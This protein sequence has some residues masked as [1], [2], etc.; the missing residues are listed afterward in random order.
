MRL[1]DGVSVAHERHPGVLDHV[2]GV[3]SVGTLRPRRVPQQRGRLL[4]EVGQCLVL[5]LPVVE[6]SSRGSIAEAHLR[7]VDFRDVLGDPCH[8]WVRR[9]LS[10]VLGYFGGTRV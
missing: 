1:L 6:E 8:G 9:L 5:A 4:H 7:F 10:V 3:L 2:V